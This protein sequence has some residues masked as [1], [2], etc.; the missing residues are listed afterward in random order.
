MQQ[1]NTAN[2]LRMNQPP[3]ETTRRNLF[4]VGPMG[5]GKTT[6]GRQVATRLGLEFIDCDQEIER[7]TGATVNLIFDIEGETGFRD[8][9]SALIEELS[10]RS[11]LLVATGGG[12]VIRSANRQRMRRSGFVV[13]LRTPVEHQIARLG[14]DRSRPLLQAPDREHILQ[15][16]AEERNPLYTDVSDLVFDSSQRNFKRVAEQ[17]CLEIC[18]SWQPPMEH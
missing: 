17:L 15:R 8:R 7:R 10:H 16:L 1:P 12:A 13:W 9:E 18:K 14:R 11:G 4:L 5:S 6:L 3:A 2:R